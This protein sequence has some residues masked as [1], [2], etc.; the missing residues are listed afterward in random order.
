MKTKKI[1]NLYEVA[2]WTNQE[3]LEELVAEVKSFLV[4]INEEKILKKH[5]RFGVL[6]WLWGEINKENLPKL[7]KFLKTNQL[8][9]Q[10]IILKIKEKKNES[11]SN[12]SFKETKEDL[13]DIQKLDEKL[14]EIL[15]I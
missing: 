1:F 5:S 6:Y 11:K 3:N 2:F 9:K 12:Q 15:N 13:V 8:V 10:F 4:K 14:S 7:E